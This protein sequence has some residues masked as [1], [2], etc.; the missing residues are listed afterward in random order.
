MIELAIV[1]STILVGTLV[2]IQSHFIS[3]DII[4]RENPSVNGMIF[5]QR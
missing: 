2:F 3:E 1:G 4:N 5:T